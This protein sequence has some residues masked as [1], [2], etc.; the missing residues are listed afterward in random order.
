MHR[1]MSE[2]STSKRNGGG[3]CHTGQ[4]QWLYNSGAGWQ[5]Q[6]HE[7][8]GGWHDDGGGRR[9][10]GR[11]DGDQQQGHAGYWRKLKEEQKK[12]KQGD[13]QHDTPWQPAS[14]FMGDHR[15]TTGFIGGR[16]SLPA[17][18]MDLST[19]T[20]SRPVAKPAETPHERKNLAQR[21][22][23]RHREM[24]KPSNYPTRSRH[25]MGGIRRHP[26]SHVYR[27][28]WPF[29]EKLMNQAVKEKCGIDN[30]WEQFVDKWKQQGQVAHVKA[31]DKTTRL[32]KGGKGNYILTMCGHWRWQ[33]FFY[34]QKQG[35]HAQQK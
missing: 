27:L 35:Q 28:L 25:H 9:D 11:H 14:K 8:H 7:G 6:W 23:M 10:G 34:F 5:G 22:Q 2:G 4:S 19:A 20:E 31:R 13:R 3:W 16:E 1:K 26:E 33:G 32:Y 21:M 17:Y 29:G 12:A 30:W 15:Q 24:I 18:G